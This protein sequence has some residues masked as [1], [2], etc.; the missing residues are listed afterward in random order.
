M[1]KILRNL[2]I[3][4]DSRINFWGLQIHFM[5]HATRNTQDPYSA[6][7]S[8]LLEEEF[9]LSAMKDIDPVDLRMSSKMW[10]ERG[11]V[12]MRKTFEYTIIWNWSFQRWECRMHVEDVC[13]PAGWRHRSRRIK[14]LWIIL[15]FFLRWILRGNPWKKDSPLAALQGIQK[16]FIILRNQ[17]VQARMI[18]RDW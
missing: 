17:C 2:K 14:D 3:E 5:W 12:P 8:W 11:L 18:F 10:E 15:Q 4:P 9:L 6:L 16:C 7:F 1:W 13:G